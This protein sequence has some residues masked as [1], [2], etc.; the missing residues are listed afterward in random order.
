MQRNEE[1]RRVAGSGAPLS[2]TPAEVSNLVRQIDLPPG[3]YSLMDGIAK[4][5]WINTK[6]N[7]DCRILFAMAAAFVAGCTYV[8]GKGGSGL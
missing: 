5:Y 2:L 4:M 3:T 6:G 1:P 7:R 8:S